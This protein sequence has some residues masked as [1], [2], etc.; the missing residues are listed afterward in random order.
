M[1]NE[2]LEA[3]K[4]NLYGGARKSGKPMGVPGSWQV[5]KFA[6]ELLEVLEA[7]PTLLEEDTIETFRVRFLKWQD[8]KSKIINKAKG[9]ENEK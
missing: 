5:G 7:A 9:L 4:E 1:D 3:A 8:G 6:Y 2:A